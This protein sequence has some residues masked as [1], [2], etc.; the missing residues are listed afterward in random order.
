MFDT[1][2]KKCLAINKIWASATFLRFPQ[3]FINYLSSGRLKNRFQVFRCYLMVGMFK[4]FWIKHCLS[5]VF[6]NSLMKSSFTQTWA[7]GFRQT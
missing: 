2:L 1:F 7:T 5:W 6:T 3:L 4:E